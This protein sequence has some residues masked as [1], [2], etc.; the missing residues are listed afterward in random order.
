MASSAR[1]ILLIDDSAVAL[2]A[3]RTVLG[4][5]SDW[6]IVGEAPNGIAGLTLFR[7]TKPDVV[8]VDFQMPGMNG[9]EVGQEIRRASRDVLLILFSLHAGTQLEEIA[10]QAGFNAVLSKTAPYPIVGIIETMKSHVF[11]PA[12]VAEEGADDA[13]VPPVLET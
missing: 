9:L 8:I 4:L 10:K 11:T 1:R 12:R 3:L 2:K 13:H 6:H 5:Q 7:E